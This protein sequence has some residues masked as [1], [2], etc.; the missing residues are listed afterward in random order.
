[1]LLLYWKYATTCPPFIST[2]KCSTPTLGVNTKNMLD[3]FFIYPDTP[4]SLNKCFKFFYYY[5]SKFCHKRGM[6]LCK[7]YLKKERE[8]KRKSIERMDKCPKEK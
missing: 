2:Q 8:R 1:M 7:N 5:L 4:N 3:R 6:G